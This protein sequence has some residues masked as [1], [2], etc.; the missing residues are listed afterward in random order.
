MSINLLPEAATQVFIALGSNLENPSTQVERGMQLLDELEHTRLL[1]RSSLYR[2]A[3]V[4]KVDQ[5]DFINA[6]VQI[7]TRLAPHDL[8]VALLSIE[9][10]VGRVRT[11]QN[12][13][14]VLDLD[15][16][17]FGDLQCCDAELILPHPR[18]HER[19]FVLQPL[20]EITGE[21]YISGHGSATNCLT[22][23]ADQLLER[24]VPS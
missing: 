10:A 2:S 3:P 8:L 19:A 5:P 16:L 4:G 24:I 17:L 22:A 7:Q 9:Q 13:P 15:I 12:A 14:R 1:K 11:Y 18:M 21:C 6:V 20:L 23:C